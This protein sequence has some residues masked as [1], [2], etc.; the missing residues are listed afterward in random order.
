MKT[1]TFQFTDPKIVQLKYNKNDDFDLKEKKVKLKNNFSV[2]TKDV[3]YEDM[4]AIVTLI[5]EVGEESSDQPFYLSIE[6]S[7]KFHSNEKISDDEF[8]K[9]LNINAPALLLSY[10]RPI[11]SLITA[12]AG[13]PAIHLP[14]VNFTED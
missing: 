4:N 6:V 8:D 11:I 13:F 12:Q 2:N 9:Y 10:S 14:F 3:S 1:S 7:A 5:T